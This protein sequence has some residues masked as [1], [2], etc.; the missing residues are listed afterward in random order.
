MATHGT[1]PCQ[2]RH[3]YTV[4]NLQG[5]T[6]VHCADTQCT[7]HVDTPPCKIHTVYMWRTYTG[8]QCTAHYC[9]L[10]YTVHCALLYTVHC[11]AC[12]P[13]VYSESGAQCTAHGTHS[14]AYT[15]TYTGE[16]TAHV[17]HGQQGPVYLDQLQAGDARA[18]AGRL[19]AAMHPTDTTTVSQT[20]T[21]GVSLSDRC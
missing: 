7:V 10:L 15:G 13:Y 20:D 2:P 6:C 12:A 16:C 11:S 8:A 14:R 5:G 9:T 21:T 1:P 4:G 18:A 19:C 17:T 3:M